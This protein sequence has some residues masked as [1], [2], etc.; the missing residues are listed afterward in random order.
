MNCASRSILSCQ[1]V[2]TAHQ[3]WHQY[4][5]L[6]DTWLRGETASSTQAS[7]DQVIIRMLGL[8]HS[9]DVLQV[10]RVNLLRA[11]PR[12]G[13]SD[14]TLCDVRQVEL[15]TLLHLESGGFLWEITKQRNA[16][17]FQFPRI[18]PALSRWLCSSQYLTVKVLSFSRC[19]QVS[20]RYL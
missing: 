8:E 13:H 16:R 10:V 7:T 9:R 4:C 5:L 2:M 6:F 3:P 18:I 12:E 1:Y 19:V 20:S 15:V 11:A 17:G 14:D